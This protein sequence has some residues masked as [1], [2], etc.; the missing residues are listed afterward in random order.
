[1]LKFLK[2][3]KE[4]LLSASIEKF[5]T[6]YLEQKNLGEVTAFR[7]DSN[8]RDIYLTLLLRKEKNPLEI[9]VL[10]YNF[11]KEKEKG[12]F[13]FDSIKTSR[14]W[15]SKTLE[16]IIGSEDKKIKIPDKYVKIVGIFL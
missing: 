3:K 5:I 4:A 9:V 10:N 13:T 8:K 16:R 14:D 2:N 6:A 11:I 15:K 1:M 7:L 12:F